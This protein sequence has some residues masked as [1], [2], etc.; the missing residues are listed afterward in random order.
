MRRE[1]VRNR[2]FRPAGTTAAVLLVRLLAACLPRDSS[3]SSTQPASSAQVRAS[4]PG[5]AAPPTKA[6]SPA[7]SVTLAHTEQQAIT[8]SKIGQ[9][10]ELLVSLPD[11]YGSRDRS[12]H[13]AGNGRATR[14]AADGA[15]P[16]G[17]AACLATTSA[18]RRA[19]RSVEILP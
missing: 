1:N 8:A 2:G 17:W 9:R 14:H 7:P 16:S 15:S 4:S 18:S 3:T 6:E 13:V 12:G 11:D 5:S 19:W 10:Y